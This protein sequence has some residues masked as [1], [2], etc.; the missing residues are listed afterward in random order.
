[1][2][3]PK[4]RVQTQAVRGRDIE[5]TVLGQHLDELLSSVGS[6]VLVEGALGWGRAVSSVK[7]WRWRV[8]CRYGLAVAD[9]ELL[10]SGP[11]RSPGAVDENDI[12]L[13]SDPSL[14]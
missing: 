4:A 10:L 3:P 2:A 1:M 6:V 14:I 5:L 12:R 13:A 9:A 11:R 7:W 8:V